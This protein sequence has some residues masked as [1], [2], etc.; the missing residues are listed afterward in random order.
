MLAFA[1]DI[2][3]NKPA[4]S[5]ESEDDELKQYMDYQRKLNHERL[6]HHSLDY[7]KNQLQE[8]IDSSDSEKL[9]Q[10]LQNFFAVSHQFADGE[11]LM[12]MLRKLMNSQNSTNN[13]YRM[14][15]F[16]HSVVFESMQQFVGVYNQMLVE[17]PEKAKDLGASEG[18]EVDFE[19]W[20]YLYFPDMDFHIGK[21]LSYTHYPFA[22]R[23]KAIEEKWQEKI[24]EGKSKAEALKLIQDD[25]EIDDTSVKILLGQKVTPPD[26]E[27]LYTSVENPIYEALTEVEDGRWGVMDG[28][29]LLDHSYYMGSHLKVWEWRKRE[30]VEK[31][32]EMVINEMSKSSN[33]K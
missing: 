13:W 25:Y 29:S 14:N 24:K 17:S 8:N 6:V 12:L 11:T 21:S 23:N 30:E 5:K 18:V 2:T 4:N 19:D 20:A 31:E 7:S 28:E 15:S 3:Q 16:Y 26:L 9:S 22:K 33:K 1:L 10:F 32:T 27:L